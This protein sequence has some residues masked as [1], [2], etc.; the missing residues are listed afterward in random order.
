MGANGYIISNPQ[1]NY[2]ISKPGAGELNSRSSQHFAQISGQS[3]HAHTG[4]LNYMNGP[5]SPVFV[6][7]PG[8]TSLLGMD[9]GVYSRIQN[10]PQQIYAP[11]HNMQVRYIRGGK[12]KVR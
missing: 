6:P 11:H 3:K 4:N 12:L 10:C 1:S 5:S 9:G 2:E 7:T 8:P